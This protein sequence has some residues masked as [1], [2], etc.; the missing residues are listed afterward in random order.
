[1]KR[2][3]TAS[4]SKGYSLAGVELNSTQIAA[5]SSELTITPKGFKNAA[6]C[7][8]KTYAD[9]ATKLREIPWSMRRQ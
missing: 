5:A 3:T 8:W 9:R 4:F 2:G 7:G 1:M 6:I